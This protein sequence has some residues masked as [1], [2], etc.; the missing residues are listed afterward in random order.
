MANTYLEQQLELL[1]LI[2]KAYDYNK[3]MDLGNHFLERALV[4]QK[5]TIYDLKRLEETA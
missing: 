5:R 1:D 4:E 2:Q 3:A